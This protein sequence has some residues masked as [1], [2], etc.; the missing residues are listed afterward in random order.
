MRWTDGGDKM[1]IRKWTQ[2]SGHGAEVDKDMEEKKSTWR[3]VG[4]EGEEVPM[5]EKKR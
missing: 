5:K 1:D 3:R 4:H 2:R